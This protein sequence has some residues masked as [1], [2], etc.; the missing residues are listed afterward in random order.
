MLQ[1]LLVAGIAQRYGPQVVLL[2]ELVEEVG[3]QYHRFGYRYLG[4]FELVQ[5]GV[6]LDDV[7]EEC[8]TTALTAQRTLADTGKVSIAV[9]LQT[10]EHSYYTNVLHPTVLYDGVEDNLSVGI[11]ILQLMPGNM[12]QEGRN[13][14]DGTCGKPAAHV[15][16][17]YVV[18][19]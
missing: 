19:H 13:G 6:A 11:H 1:Y 8:Q 18:E 15:V 10:V 17:T 12:F 9:E 16:A 5:L 7:I 14:E 4:L 2:H 3:T